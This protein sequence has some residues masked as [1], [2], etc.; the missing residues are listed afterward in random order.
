MAAD[1]EQGRDLTAVH[2]KPALLA[3]LILRL[4]E[5]PGPPA[6]PLTGRKRPGDERSGRSSTGHAE[7]ALASEARLRIV[8]LA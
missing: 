7:Q 6:R 8:G 4:A 1:C 3:R 2:I 5:W